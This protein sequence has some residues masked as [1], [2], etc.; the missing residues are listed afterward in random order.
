VCITGG[1]PTMYG[2]LSQFCLMLKNA[3]MKVKL[4]TNGMRPN[5]L[6]EL[7][8]LE[9]IDY[10]A[11][12]IKS[13]LTV[14]KYSAATGVSF[15]EEMLALPL[16]SIKLIM[17]AA[18]DYEFRTTVVPTFHVPKD[19]EQICKYAIKGAKRY[20]IQNFHPCDTLI[21]P[22]L[23]SIKPFTSA[24]LEAFADAAKP[25]VNEVKIRNV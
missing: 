3:G 1:E 15:I 2:D 5:V 20:V 25:Y 6:F 16:E 8:N 23:E 24:E 4:D 9:L 12:D 17:A 10:I 13:P 14:E 21:D 18:P 7:L 19:I 22:H 11:M